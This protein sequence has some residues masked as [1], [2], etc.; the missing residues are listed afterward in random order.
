MEEIYTNL[1]THL[2]SKADLSPR[3]PF[4]YGSDMP[5]PPCIHY[6]NIH[7]SIHALKINTNLCLFTK[8]FV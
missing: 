1:A 2:W 5:A 8:V 4:D 7:F 3:W 6:A